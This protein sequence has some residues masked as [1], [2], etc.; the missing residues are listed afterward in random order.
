MNFQIVLFSFVQDHHQQMKSPAM[1]TV[2]KWIVISRCGY[3]N[4]VNNDHFMASN[5]TFPSRSSVANWPSASA[6]DSITITDNTKC[7]IIFMNQRFKW[8]LMKYHLL[9]INLAR[10]KRQRQMSFLNLEKACNLK[11]PTHA[12]RWDSCTL[13]IL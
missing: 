1:Q 6:W 7:A 5:F 12:R 13:P 11:K 10:K 3:N 2:Y 9:Q 8:F 4:R